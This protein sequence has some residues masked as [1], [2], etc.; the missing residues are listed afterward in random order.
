MLN[1][2]LSTPVVFIVFNG[3]EPTSK[4]FSEIAKA[5][6]KKLFVIADGPRSHVPEDAKK[7]AETR[8][9]IKLVAYMKLDKSQIL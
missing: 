1:Y 4:V 2:E 8:E 3:P 6:P 9:I 7:I 5:K